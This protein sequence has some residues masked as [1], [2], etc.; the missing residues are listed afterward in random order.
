MGAASSV[1][2]AALTSEIRSEITKQTKPNQ[3]PESTLSRAEKASM[4]QLKEAGSETLYKR[5]NQ[6]I[7]DLEVEPFFYKKQLMLFQMRRKI[8]RENTRYNICEI[9][10]LSTKRFEQVLKELEFNQP[11]Q[12]ITEISIKLGKEAW[13]KFGAP[14]ILSSCLLK[15]Q[16]S[17]IPCVC[18]DCR[19]NFSTIWQV[20][21]DAPEA[22]PLAELAIRAS[23]IGSLKNLCLAK[24]LELGLEQDGLPLT[25]QK[26]LREG[27]EPG[28]LKAKRQRAVDMMNMVIKYMEPKIRV[29]DQTVVEE[30]G[31]G[32]PMTPLAWLTCEMR[33]SQMRL[34]FSIQPLR[35]VAETGYVDKITKFF[36]EGSTAGI[37]W[38]NKYYGHVVARKLL[39]IATQLQENPQRTPKMDEVLDNPDIRLFL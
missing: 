15:L 1:I 20:M 26:T 28:V 37:K 10:F 34:I 12:E 8:L 22:G 30:A 2:K 6:K 14:T 3:P 21:N 18:T 32:Q 33:T 19:T 24:V 27:P 36:I 4:K 23:L 39:S 9:D 16:H 5:L 29:L 25:L 38:L 31:S 17:K 7:A 11:G 35:L 13:A